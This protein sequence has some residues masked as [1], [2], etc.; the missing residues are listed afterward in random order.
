MTGRGPWPG[1]KRLAGFLAAAVMVGW[2]VAVSGSAVAKDACSPERAEVT[3]STVPDT[4]A[5]G[6]GTIAYNR[7]RPD[8]SRAGIWVA[9]ADGGDAWRL[10]E[11]GS[12]PVWSPGGDRIAYEESATGEVRV[13]DA[14][15]TNT[16]SLASGSRPVWSPDGNLI[17]YEDW[18]NGEV[19]L[20]D[21]DGTDRRRLASGWGPVWS[22]DGDR[23]A[24]SDG[25]IWTMGADGANPRLLADAGSDA[26]W[27]PDGRRIVYY[28]S[29]A[30]AGVWV[31]DA[32]GGDRWWLAGGYDPAWSP[33]GKRIAYA[34]GGEPYGIWVV[35][36]DGSN[37]RQL[38][39]GGSS[40]RW[41]P[42]GS[43]ITYLDL[44][45]DQY[46]FDLWVVDLDGGERR[47]L[48]LK[49]HDP[50]WS[51][52]GKRIAY[53]IGVEYVPEIWV[54]DAAGHRM[55]ADGSGPAW[56]VD[57]GRI[58]YTRSDAEGI[59]VWVMGV[60]GSDT[61]RLARRGSEPAWSPDGHRIAYSGHGGAVWVVE[62]DSGT[63]RR[64]TDD[65]RPDSS[66]G[67]L[68]LSWSPDGAHIIYHRWV[69][70]SG[71]EVWVVAAD[72][73]EHRRLIDGSDPAWSPD[74]RRIAYEKALDF[75][76]E[77][78]VTDPSGDSPQRLADG[79]SPV[80]SPDGDLIAYVGNSVMV[81]DADGAA[82]RPVT[83][84]FG[85]AL[86]WSPDGS[87]LAYFTT[88]DGRS[89][90]W[91]VDMASSESWL[92]AEGASRPAWSPA[93]GARTGPS[94]D[95]PADAS[96]PWP[97]FVWGCLM[98]LLG[99][100]VMFWRHRNRARPSRRSSSATRTGD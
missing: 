28:Q 46:V 81:M 30:D 50:A 15:G 67:G 5:F 2:S 89:E 8:A 82:G 16:R 14:D 40:P 23:I 65:W 77:V 85:W 64:L 90:V 52:D 97:T 49:G 3:F 19:W 91:V 29:G 7:Q 69:A 75:T 73:S 84:D 25:G 13:M 53:S 55:L 94:E 51:P 87:H 38:A 6:S 26:A 9:D 62:A 37:R 93:L 66:Y 47:R 18:A 74:G 43:H 68:N 36:A 88:C 95:G 17:A 63:R 61:R 1:R 31:A 12:L 39:R 27:S 60:D 33:D 44:R 99:F 76:N 4:T 22:P 80:W 11:S 59:G 83:G 71:R 42:D 86:A 92:L 72:G 34:D 58:A 78:W 32:D 21:V 45:R 98:L 41:S 48:A 35:D 20:A 10:A 57:G 70:D 100:V 96:T 79:S 56:S 24:Y 54:A